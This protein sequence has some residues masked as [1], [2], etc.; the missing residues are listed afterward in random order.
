VCQLGI[1][2]EAKNLNPKKRGLLGRMARGC[3]GLPKFSPTPAMSNPSTPCGRSTPET[4]LWPFQGW[5]ARKAG[6]LRPSSTPL[7][8]PRRTPLEAFTPSSRPRGSPSMPRFDNPDA[9]ECP[10]PPQSGIKAAPRPCEEPLRR[11]PPSRTLGFPFGAKG[12]K[13]SNTWEKPR[14][15]REGVSKGEV[16]GCKPPALQAVHPR[17]GR[18]AVW[19]VARPQGV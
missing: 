17:N 1:D 13:L 6:G 8:T 4:D 15:V 16:D 3:H 18:K 7:V 5:P 14:P 10:T 12:R 2:F 19:G 11:P 9:F